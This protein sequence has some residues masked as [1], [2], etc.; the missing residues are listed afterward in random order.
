LALAE[1]LRWARVA[2]WVL[3]V[4]RLSPA[5]VAARMHPA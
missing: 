2:P 4:E 1:T 3:P 5:V